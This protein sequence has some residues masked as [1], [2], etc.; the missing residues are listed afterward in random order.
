MSSERNGFFKIIATLLCR[1]YQ[2]L[3]T[4]HTQGPL[5]GSEITLTRTKNFLLYITEMYHF[6]VIELSHLHIST[7]PSLSAQ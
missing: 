1:L 6:A 3:D 2:V 5:Q 4:V 7:I